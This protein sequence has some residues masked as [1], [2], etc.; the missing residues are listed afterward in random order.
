MESETALF[1]TAFSPVPLEAEDWK[2]S[3]LRK[4]WHASSYA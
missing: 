3:A 2:I 1:L 4:C